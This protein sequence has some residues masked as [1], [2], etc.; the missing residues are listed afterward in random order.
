MEAVS[1][2]R[3]QLLLDLFTTAI[4]GGINYWAEVESYHYLKDG[5]D[6]VLGFHAVIDEIEAGCRYTV[7][8]SVIDMGLRRARRTPGIH[9]ST[10]PPPVVVTDD[11]DWD[12]DAGDADM[13]VQLGLFGEVVYG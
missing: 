5:K 13:I 10:E 1:K 2:A 11:T 12:F 7:D 8:R 6:D 4:E 3:D 9:F